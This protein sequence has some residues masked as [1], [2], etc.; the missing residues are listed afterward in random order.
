MAEISAKDSFFSI[1][2]LSAISRRRKRDL[3]DSYGRE[4]KYMRISITDR[5]NLRCSYC[6][7]EEVEWLPMEKILT[8]EEIEFICRE[9]VALGI[10]CFKITGGEP[11][12][13]KD[14]VKLIEK[15][16]KVPGVEQVTL[17]TNGVLLSEHIDGLINAGLDAV[18]I[19]LD[20]LDEEKYKDITGAAELPKV[21][22]SIEDAL[23]RGMKVKVNVVLQQGVNDDEW[24]Q[25]TGLAKK[26]PV[27]VRFIELMPIGHGKDGGQVSNDWIFQQIRNVYGDHVEKDREKHGNGPAEYYRIEGFQ[28][29]IGFISAIHGKFCDKCN[30]IRLT[31]TGEIKPCL[32]YSET[33]SVRDIARERDADGVRACLKKAIEKKPAMH[34]FER[35]EKVTEKKNM[36]QIGG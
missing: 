7:P 16:K 29:S 10:T 26:Y 3:K 6:M 1:E 22:D 27:D 4:I 36:S 18:N 32:C 11:L 33:I 35:D 8:F 19:S 2:S 20:T 5:C 23:H 14:C 15:L 34:Q 30:R 12:V 13:R 31:S 17:T 28:G 25:L 21:L 9:A 24:Q